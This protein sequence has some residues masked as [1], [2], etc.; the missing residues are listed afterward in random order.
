MFQIARGYLRDFMLWHSLSDMFSYQHL[1]F[2]WKKGRYWLLI[3]T[4]DNSEYHI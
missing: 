1:L 2:V 4:E 3:Q